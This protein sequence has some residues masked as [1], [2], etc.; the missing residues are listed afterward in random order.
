MATTYK[1]HPAIGIARVGNSPDELISRVKDRNSF[2]ASAAAS[3]VA[4]IRST[5]MLPRNLS[6]RW[7]L[8][9]FVQLTFT[10]GTD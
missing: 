1:I 9:V 4:G 2:E 3:E 8:S 7:M 10:P 5:A 6:V